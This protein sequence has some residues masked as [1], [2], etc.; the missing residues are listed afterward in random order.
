[1]RCQLLK[2]IK[3]FCILGGSSSLAK[4]LIS[5][6]FGILLDDVEGEL[7]GVLLL[8]LHLFKRMLAAA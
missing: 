8:S 1:M 4:D 6:G 5:E 3:K 2:E 7:S